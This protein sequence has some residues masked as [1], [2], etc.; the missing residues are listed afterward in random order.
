MKFRTG[1]AGVLEH[2]GRILQGQR[3]RVAQRPDIDAGGQLEEFPE[4][5]SAAPSEPNHADP[6]GRERRGGVLRIEHGVFEIRSDYSC[7]SFC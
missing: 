5:A 6:D 3:I 2:S 4:E 1:P 7:S